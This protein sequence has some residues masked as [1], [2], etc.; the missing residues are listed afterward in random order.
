MK[1]DFPTA[2][3]IDGS[4]LGLRSDPE[5]FQLK[6]SATLSSFISSLITAGI[7]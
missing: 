4:F 6:Y 2:F 7:S 1:R 5:Y 3:G